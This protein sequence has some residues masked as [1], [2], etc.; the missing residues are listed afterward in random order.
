MSCSFLP[1]QKNIQK[2]ILVPVCFML[3]ST[4][5]KQQQQQK[6]KTK[7]TEGGDSVVIL[8]SAKP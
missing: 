2:E 3:H 6:E 5:V 1:A 7:Y 8:E 4:I